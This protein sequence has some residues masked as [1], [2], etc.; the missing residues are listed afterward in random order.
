[1]GDPVAVMILAEDQMIHKTKELA[2]QSSYSVLAFVL[3]AV[4]IPHELFCL[5]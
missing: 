4:V 1:M 3:S 2:L 5:Y